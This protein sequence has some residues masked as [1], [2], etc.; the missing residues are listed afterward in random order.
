MIRTQIQLT[1]E[2]AKAIKTL[3]MKRNTSVAELIRRSVDELLQKAVGGD[4]AERRRRAL[5]AAGRFH[6]GKTDISR[7]H[8]DYLAEAYRE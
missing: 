8:D 7:N 1:E 5:A 6:S 4:L 3:A 2:Q